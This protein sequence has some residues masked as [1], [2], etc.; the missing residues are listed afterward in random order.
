MGPAMGSAVGSAVGSARGVS[1]HPHRKLLVAGA[2]IMIPA[3][4][5]GFPGVTGNGTYSAEI[6]GS[7]ALPPVPPSSSTNLSNYM[8]ELKATSG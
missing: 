8:T 3:P 2:P 4:P 6:G 1:Q 5:G 7:L